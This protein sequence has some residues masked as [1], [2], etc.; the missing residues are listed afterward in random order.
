MLIMT[1]NAKKVYN[2]IKNIP[3]GKVTTYKIIA[4]KLNIKS[5]R[6][7]GQILKKN[8]NA[9]TVPCHRVVK[10]TGDLGGYA[11][12]NTEAK[13]KILQTEG[14]LIKNGKVE[15]FSNIIYRF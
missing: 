10:S 13:I 6:A 2:L 7:V 5:Y 11:G 1:E 12:T 3:K 15:N 4:N 8:P 9:P 14:V